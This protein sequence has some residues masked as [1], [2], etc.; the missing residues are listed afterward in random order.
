MSQ[1][2]KSLYSSPANHVLPNPEWR[3]TPLRPLGI[4]RGAFNLPESESGIE[5]MI[6]IH[7]F[8]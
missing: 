5:I 8:I 7:R 1:T 2:C 3:Q 4:T 6:L